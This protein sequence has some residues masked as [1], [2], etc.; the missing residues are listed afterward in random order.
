MEIK[1]IEVFSE[2]TNYAIVR[3]PEREFPG[4]DVQGNSVSIL[5]SCAERASEL[6]SRTASQRIGKKCSLGTRQKVLPVH[7][8]K[9]LSEVTRQRMGEI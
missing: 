6:A 4:C 3:I 9:K 1:G 5:L 8:R 2:Q 7:R